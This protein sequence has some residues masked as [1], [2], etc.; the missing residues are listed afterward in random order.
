MTNEH[1]E[2][3]Q[4]QQEVIPPTPTEVLDGQRQLESRDSQTRTR[5]QLAIAT[6]AMGTPGSHEQARRQWE[7]IGEAASQPTD[8]EGMRA[9]VEQALEVQR[10]ADGK[11]TGSM[12]DDLPEMGKARLLR[13]GADAQIYIDGKITVIKGPDEKK[14]MNEIDKRFHKTL[15]IIHI[16]KDTVLGKIENKYREGSTYVLPYN[17]SFMLDRSVIG[18]DIRWL[19]SPLR[20]PLGSEGPKVEAEREKLFRGYR[21]KLEQI[22]NS[23]TTPEGEHEYVTRYGND[24][25]NRRMLEKFCRDPNAVKGAGKFA[26]LLAVTALLALWAI[27]DIKSGKLSFGTIVLIGAA[28]FLAQSGPKNSFMASEQFANLSGRIGKDGIESLKGFSQRNPSAY[29]HLIATLK[30]RTANDSGITRENIGILTD[31]KL[32]NRKVPEEIAELFIGDP[33]PAESAYV[34][35]RMR[36]V[37]DRAGKEVMYSLADANE[38]SDGA[39]DELK[40]LIPTV[41]ATETETT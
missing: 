26:M 31:K 30:G 41:T 29:G 12:I 8:R 38:N 7:Q 3:R 24:Q 22:K 39:N 21:E 4:G 9:R 34:L 20:I 35:E 27:K 16:G 23:L 5:T 25:G 19:S 13:S 2:I 10:D 28:M 15:S 14:R 6:Q 18:E 36:G 17:G 1:I 32:G 33:K 11:V 40:R 37:R